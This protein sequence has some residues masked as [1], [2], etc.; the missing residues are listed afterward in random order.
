MTAGARPQG[1]SFPVAM[2]SKL[3]SA[4]AYIG[5]GNP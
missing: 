1:G 3:T 5:R 2:L 4:V